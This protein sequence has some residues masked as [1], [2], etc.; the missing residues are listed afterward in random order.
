MLR[1]LRV[2]VHS[3]S[4]NSAPRF[5]IVSKT[6]DIRAAL[7]ARYPAPAWA[8]FEEVS[9]GT[10]TLHKRSADALAM[11]L[12][13]SRGLELHGFEIKA[14]RSDW[15]A[16][17]DNPAKAEEIASRCHRWW[18]VA[19]DRNI[20]KP[21]E[22]PSNWGLLVMSGGKLVQKTEA[23]KL[24][25]APLTYSFLA[26]ILRRAHE[27]LAVMVPRT[28][29]DSEVKRLLAIEKEKLE[30][31]LTRRS[32][33]GEL[34]RLREIVASIEKAAGCQI[35]ESWTGTRAGKAIKMVLNL[36]MEST[37]N[38]IDHA[39]KIARVAADH[40]ADAVKRARGLS[41]Q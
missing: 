5:R 35:N 24:N 39:E 14:T 11:S 28:D 29:V 15:V 30:E 37:I 34:A 12:W 36:D 17:R 1:V 23:S 26:A 16:E 20:V 31:R 8:Y 18:I 27:Q 6:S 38:R 41:E 21:G 25:A 40:L 13:P 9:N 2:R 22:L 10:G 19:G 7:R 4:E 33:D 3:R 32:E